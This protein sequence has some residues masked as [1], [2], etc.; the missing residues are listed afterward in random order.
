MQTRTTAS[1]PVSNPLIQLELDERGGQRL[2]SC[3]PAILH[4]SNC[5]TLSP[6]GMWQRVLSRFTCEAS[7]LAGKLERGAT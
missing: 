1:P 5:D 2:D 6:L 3:R 4:S 7:K